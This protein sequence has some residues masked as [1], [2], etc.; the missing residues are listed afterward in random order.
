MF[1]NKPVPPLPN[2]KSGELRANLIRTL[3]ELK[4]LRATIKTHLLDT[5]NE[6]ENLQAALDGMDAVTKPAYPNNL[7]G[8]PL[9]SIPTTVEKQV[10]TKQNQGE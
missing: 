4:D 9:A 7:V 6:L 2:L 1:G 5:E 10:K 3:N 8:T